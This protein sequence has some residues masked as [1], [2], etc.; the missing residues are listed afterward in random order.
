MKKCPKCGN[1]MDRNQRHC[2][3]CDYEEK[4]NKRKYC[5]VCGELLIKGVCYKC[6]YRKLTSANTCPYCRQKL[7]GGRCDRCN[8]VKPFAYTRYRVISILVVIAILW[9]ISKL[10]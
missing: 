4:N 5:P 1:K 8:Y 7:I 6:G 2:L 9:L 3:A 10:T